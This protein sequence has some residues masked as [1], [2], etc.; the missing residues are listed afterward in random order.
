M[1]E[2]PNL[3]LSKVKLLADPERQDA[4]FNGSRGSLQGAKFISS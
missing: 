1:R 4:Q 3:T 2:E